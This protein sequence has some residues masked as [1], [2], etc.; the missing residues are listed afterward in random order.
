[1]ILPHIK[2]TIKGMLNRLILKAQAHNISWP[3]FMKPFGVIRF[4][5]HYT[6]VKH[7][8]VSPGQSDGTGSMQ[9]RTPVLSSHFREESTNTVAAP[10]VD[11]PVQIASRYCKG[12]S[13]M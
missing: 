8:I 13:D 7:T 3:G 4:V 1:M 12:S 2:H 11:F 6:S 5:K 10:N 9:T